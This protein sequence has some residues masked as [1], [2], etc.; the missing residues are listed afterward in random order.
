[1]IK[2]TTIYKIQNQALIII[3]TK[4]AHGNWQKVVAGRGGQI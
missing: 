1:M 4:D 3:K 2:H